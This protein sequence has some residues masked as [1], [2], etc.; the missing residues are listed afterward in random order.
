LVAGSWHGG[1]RVRGEM[2][3]VER[4]AEADAESGSVCRRRQD[5]AD[6]EGELGVSGG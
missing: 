5:G 3:D 1:E 6:G 2:A 4:R